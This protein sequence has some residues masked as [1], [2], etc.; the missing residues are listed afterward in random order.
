MKKENIWIMITSLL[1]MII[2]SLIVSANTECTSQNCAI[3]TSL[4]LENTAPIITKVQSSLII[5]PTALSTTDIHVLFNVTDVNGYGD[6]ND[7]SAQCIG[8]KNGESSRTSSSCV[9]LDQSGNDLRYNCSVT[10]Q[11]Y[12]ASAEDWKWNC[13]VKDYSF[14]LVYND[15]IE[16]TIN[17][18]NYI[19]QDLSSFTWTSAISYTID[20]EADEPII[21]YNGGNQDYESCSVTG[22]N[23]TDGESHTIEASQFGVA[24][25][26]GD[27]ANVMLE[28]G[29]PSEFGTFFTLPHG[30]GESE[31]IYAYVNIPALPSGVYT[32]TESWLIEI[33]A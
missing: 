8:Y 22:Y 4:S 11:Y 21:L 25:V 33:S 3:G 28:D 19:E 29:I 1:M 15:T 27:A 31:N 2:L 14:E 26:G 32:T 23:S 12:D 9:A 6:L 10:F 17:S 24:N 5:T 18:L 13:S 16:F 30:N 7:S 20:Q